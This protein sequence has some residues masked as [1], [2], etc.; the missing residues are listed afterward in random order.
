MNIKSI[1]LLSSVLLLAA[2]A[3]PKTPY[4]YT[5][6]KQAHPRSILVLPPLNDSPDI[7][8][9]NGMLTQSVKP[10]AES[11][12]YVFP[13]ALTQETFR[14]N[15]LHHAQ[16]V[17]QVSLQKLNQIF[18]ADAVLYLKVT[19]YGTKYQVVQSD[20]RVSA[21]AVLRDSK[22]GNVLWK[23]SATASSLEDQQNHNQGILGALVSAVVNQIIDSSRDAS[24]PI[25]GVASSRLLSG[26]MENGMLYGPRSPL[27]QQDY[28]QDKT[29]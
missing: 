4:D 16:D 18:G 13:V 22:T 11:G 28:Q 10:L 17:H 2:C 12:Y 15:G 9:V 27:H 24:Y 19:E 6:F 14:Q 3:Q 1:I 21:E 5:N 20:T 29:Q 8:A 7:N 25:A 26:G 23:G